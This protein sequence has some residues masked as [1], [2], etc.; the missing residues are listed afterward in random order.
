MVHIIFLIIL[1]LDYQGVERQK[2]TDFIQQKFP[3]TPTI[4]LQINTTNTNKPAYDSN[5][6]GSVTQRPS[7]LD[8]IV[9]KRLAEKKASLKA[10]KKPTASLNGKK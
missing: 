3:K 5:K 10:E 1:V 2:L 7:N 8:A 6:K 9:D 4:K